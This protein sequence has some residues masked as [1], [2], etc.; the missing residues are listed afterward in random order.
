[1]YSIFDIDFHS[2]RNNEENPGFKF[3]FNWCLQYSGMVLFSL[4]KRKMHFIFKTFRLS[5]TY[6]VGLLTD[7][8]DY[9]SS[10]AFLLTSFSKEQQDDFEMKLEKDLTFE[11]RKMFIE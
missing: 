3:E 1:M 10:F 5:N 4:T 7:A 6:L 9:I 8:K 11:R 2:M